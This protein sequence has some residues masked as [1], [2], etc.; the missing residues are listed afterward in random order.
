MKLLVSNL[1]KSHLEEN[2]KT[3][4]GE[5]DLEIYTGTSLVAQWTRICLPMQAGVVGSIPSLGRFHM[6]QSN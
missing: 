3:D 2:D 6:P 5:A 4:C 1:L